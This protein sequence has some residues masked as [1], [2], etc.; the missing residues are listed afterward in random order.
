[1]I[2]RRA[3]STIT[4]N[5]LYETYNEK[6]RGIILKQPV[7]NDPALQA[8]YDQ[9]R[10]HLLE[11]V[12]DEAEA[13]RL[14]DSLA[15]YIHQAEKNG[16]SLEGL[17]KQHPSEYAAFLVEKP[18]TNEEFRR[19]YHTIVEQSDELKPYEKTQVTREFDWAIDRL[20]E[21]KL[22]LQDIEMR[23]VSFLAYTKIEA[24]KSSRRAWNQFGW[25]LGM[26]LAFAYANLLLVMD[27]LFSLR[28]FTAPT[29]MYAIDYFGFV[30]PVLL[31]G[32]VF[33]MLTRFRH[34]FQTLGRRVLFALFIVLVYIGFVILTQPL[35]MALEWSFLIQLT[36]IYALVLL[37][38]SG[39]MASWTLIEFVWRNTRCQ[40]GN[41]DIIIYY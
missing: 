37:G 33:G 21:M 13:E 38:I 27:D 29:A 3:S 10:T 32:A 6:K 20:N 7:F 34:Q 23:D 11:L 14:L 28:L 24:M 18:S 8:Y 40:L 31:T 22:K 35:L 25:L 30:L 15:G 1:M 16:Q 12:D 41:D 9:V 26:I 36:P 39:F 19:R 4:T 5:R 2:S 17:L